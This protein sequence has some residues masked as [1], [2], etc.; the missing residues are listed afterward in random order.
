MKRVCVF[1]G[2]SPGRTPE[3]IDAAVNLGRAMAARGIGLV[4]GG[5]SVGL[6]GAIADAVLQAG[7]D[8]VGVIPESLV[9]YEVAHRG[10]PDL[11][12]VRSMHERKA[13][14]ADLAD[15]FIAMPGALGTL[16]EFFEVLTWSQLGEH[17]KPCGL[18]NVGGYYTQMLAFLDHAVDERF[19]RSQHRGMLLVE[20][21][22]I[23]MLDR[24][25]AYRPPKIEKW[26][27]RSA[28]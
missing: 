19:L 20:T 12:V 22:P 14:M 25:A 16:D 15:G 8:V 11:R 18:L 27:D 13:A 21:E 28:T 1:C 6:M 10:L 7:G 23:A 3:Y 24:L 5:A 9:K 17:T 4:Y 26:I 2:S